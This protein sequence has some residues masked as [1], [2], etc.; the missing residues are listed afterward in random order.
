MSLV[1]GGTK[2]PDEAKD[3]SGKVTVSIFEFK[4]P[5]MPI[6]GHND[7]QVNVDADEGWVCV[8]G[9]GSGNGSPGNFLD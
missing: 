6:Q 5:T 1:V 8:G 7:I 2:R 4:N 3:A 9:G